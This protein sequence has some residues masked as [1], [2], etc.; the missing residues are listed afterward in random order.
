MTMQ[1][2]KFDTP[3][4]QAREAALELLTTSDFY[5]AASERLKRVRDRRLAGPDNGRSQPMS[6]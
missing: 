6:R 1:A 3:S 5:V 4:Q 2:R